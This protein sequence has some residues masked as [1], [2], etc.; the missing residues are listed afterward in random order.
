VKGIISE[1]SEPCTV[2]RSN[3]SKCIDYLTTIFGKNIA[4]YKKNN[5]RC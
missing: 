1:I 5:S 3:L 4:I 2:K